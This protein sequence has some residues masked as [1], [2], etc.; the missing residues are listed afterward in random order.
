MKLVL[1]KSLWGVEGADDE[2]EWDSLFARIRQDGYS[3]IEC[4][5]AFSFGGSPERGAKFHAL[6][7]KH[8][9]GIICQIHTSGGYF[10][11]D[12]GEYVYCSSFELEHHLRSVASEIDLAMHANPILINCHGGVDAWDH[13]TQVRFLLGAMDIAKEKGKGVTET[14]ICFET[15]RQRIFCNPFQT[16]ALLA[17]ERIQNSPLTLTA[18]L[19]HWIVAC[20]RQ[21]QTPS[22]TMSR[23]PWWP[24][25]L[26]AVALRTRLIHCRVGHP[27]GPQV[28]DVTDKAHKKDV[29][30]FLDMW[31]EIWTVQRDR[32]QLQESICE[33]EHGP[34]P[35]LPTLPHTNGETSVL[36]AD[37]DLWQM[38]NKVAK[39]VREEFQDVDEISLQ[40]SRAS[41]NASATA[42]LQVQEGLQE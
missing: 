30:A 6:A 17:D 16:R 8:H 28:A 34:P 7:T 15:H 31:G 5:A 36:N 40:T 25:L 9:L 1:A 33:V 41:L 29:Q 4:V 2:E 32:L 20:E 24:D 14:N 26:E 19:S 39:L 11:D 10:R 3:M 38:N 37:T 12:L 21:F 18:D 27:Q 22:S 23:D 13:E 42:G 35:Y